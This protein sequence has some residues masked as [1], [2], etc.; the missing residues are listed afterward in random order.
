MIFYFI[1]FA[2]AGA[3]IGYFSKNKLTALI[4]II[5]IAILWGMTHRMIWGF[6]SMGE[7]FL[8]YFIYIVIREE[9]NLK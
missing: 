3:V 7:M 2:V 6:V 4:V 9:G 1:L 5:T 8:G